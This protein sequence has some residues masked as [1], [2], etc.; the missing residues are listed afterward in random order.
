MPSVGAVT[1]NLNVVTTQNNRTAAANEFVIA[2]AINNPIVVTL[3]TAPT[4]NSVVAVKKSDTT[5]NLVTVVPGGTAKIDVDT[6]AGLY[7]RGAT[8][9][10]QYDGTNWQVG[11]TALTNA[12]MVSQG[13]GSS[14]V[15]TPYYR[16]GYWYGRRNGI[17]T[18]GPGAADSTTPTDSSILYG[19][20]YVHQQIAIDRVVYRSGNTAPTSGAAV[21]IGVY[22]SNATTGEP[23]TLIQDFGLLALSAVTNTNNALTITGTLPSGWLHFALSFNSTTPG[24]AWGINPIYTGASAPTG[25]SDA[26]FNASYVGTAVNVPYYTQA[27]TSTAAALAT[28]AAATAAYPTTTSLIYNPEVFIRVA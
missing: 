2:D 18:S 25:I 20:M 17:G 7:I 12:A 26:Q 5:T 19:A 6:S 27:G 21:R 4:L 11:S 13:S 28:T 23:Q 10:V 22:T 9:Q 15:L 1:S 8:I 16:S 24:S 3:P 14:S